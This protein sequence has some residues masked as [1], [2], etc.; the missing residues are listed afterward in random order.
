MFKKLLIIF[1][2]LIITS[3][4][5]SQSIPSGTG[6][7]EALGFN[8]FITD[9][10]FDIIRNPA[11]GNT[12]RNYVFGDIGRADLT[13]PSLYKLKNQYIGVNFGLSPKIFAGIIFNKNEGRMFDSVFYVS[14]PW[15]MG[16]L[17]MDVPIVPIK[18]YFGFTPNKGIFSIAGSFYYA[19]KSQDS[20]LPGTN[21]RISDTTSQTNT[22]TNYNLEKKS[23]IYGFSLGS[24]LNFKDGWFEGNV[25]MRFNN[26]KYIGSRDTNITMILHRRPLPDSTII[27]QSRKTS[28][29]V[30]NDGAL[31]FNGYLRG[32]ITVNKPN[33]IKL[34]PYVSIGFFNWKPKFSPADSRNDTLPIPA[35]RT[36]TSYD[37][38]Y[39]YFNLNGGI[40][41]NMPVFENGLLGFGVSLGFNSY[42]MNS[43]YTYTEWTGAGIQPPAG[44]TVKIVTN[45][46]V[47]YKK[48]SMILPK[49]NFGLEWKFTDWM[50]ARMGY[51]RAVIW[52]KSDGTNTDTYTETRISTI[53]ANNYV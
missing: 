5:F 4:V 34:V 23:S 32:M 15:G 9:P 49:I 25:D 1:L 3:G 44:D 39:R 24:L 41:M 52:D 7:Y 45:S 31:E 16:K 38:E 26:M 48:S 37:Y 20:T 53:P 30:E 28:L 46:K 27:Q 40:G 17:G 8:P 47:E 18:M 11:W 14:S 19:Q 10:A 35:Y 21:T 33:Q 2:F 13:D 43:N 50:T 22:N 36:T 42:K 51:S 6:R 12:Y 29:S